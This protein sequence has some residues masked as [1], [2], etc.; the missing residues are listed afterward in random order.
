[1]KK[2]LLMLSCLLALASPV[3]AKKEKLRV[4]LDFHTM[5]A[6]DEAFL[7]P[8]NAIRGIAGD[9]LP[10]EIVKGVRA[11]LSTNGRLRIHVRG[12]VFTQD[13]IVPPELRG[14]NDETQFRGAVSCLTED[15]GQVIT[16]NIFTEGFPATPKGNSDIKTQIQLPEECIAPIVFILAGSEDKWFAVTGFSTE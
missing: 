14:T 5:Y 6:V 8:T 9:E 10:W 7:G 16:T 2:P 15:N 1:M 11:R 4:V 3:H 13:D 12:L